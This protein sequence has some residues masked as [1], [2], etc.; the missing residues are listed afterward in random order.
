MWRFSELGDVIYSKSND[1][2][3]LSYENLV[4]WDE[5][6]SSLCYQTGDQNF[7]ITSNKKIQNITSSEKEPTRYCTHRP[8][9]NNANYTGFNYC[10]RSKIKRRRSGYFC[11]GMKSGKFRVPIMATNN[12]WANPAAKNAFFRVLIESDQNNI[13]KEKIIFI[14]DGR[15]PTMIMNCSKCVGHT[16]DFQW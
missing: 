7:L 5:W 1:K 15:L 12:G 4:N 11:G 6:Q 16:T 8:C 3:I 13:A 14:Y 9:R 2:N 10:G